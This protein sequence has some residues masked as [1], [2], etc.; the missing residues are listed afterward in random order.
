MFFYLLFTKSFV[1]FPVI[2]LALLGAVI[3]NMA[4]TT[5]LYS[6]FSTFITVANSYIF[7]S[8]STSYGYILISLFSSFIRHVAY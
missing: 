8:T 2:R 1:I 6:N 4:L 5:T 3:H 7:C